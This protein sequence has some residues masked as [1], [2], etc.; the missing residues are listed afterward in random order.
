MRIPNI[1]YKYIATKDSQQDN[2]GKSDAGIFLFDDMVLKAQPISEESENELQMM[3]WLNG[4]IPVPNIIEHISECKYSYLLMTKCS[5][6]M[7]CARQYMIDPVKQTGLLAEAL[8]QLWSIPTEGCPCN[9]SLE[10]RLKKAAENVAAGKVD[11]DNAQPDT[12]GNGGF[13]NPE[14]LLSWLIDNRPPETP[15]VSHGDFCLPN[16]F[17]NDHGLTGLIDL[18]KAGTA[19]KWQDIALCCRS[20]SNNYSGMYDGIKYSG[21]REEMLFDALEIAPDQ[22]LIRYYRLLDE[23]F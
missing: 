20:L 21:F 14:A 9:W 12:F 5:G 22:E 1:I 4:K 15:V 13:K 10:R 7:S 11:T 17:I 16:I 18:G 2:I 8:H 23:L 6:Q 3:R 19:D